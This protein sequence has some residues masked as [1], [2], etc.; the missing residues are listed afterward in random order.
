[1]ERKERYSDCKPARV[2]EKKPCQICENE[3]K[4][5]RYHPESTCWF[6]KKMEKKEETNKKFQ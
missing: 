3:K 6:R 2:Q 1:M 4:R 5:K